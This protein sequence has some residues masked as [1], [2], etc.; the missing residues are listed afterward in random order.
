ME[1][2]PRLRELQREL[3]ESRQ[4]SARLLGESRAEAT[5]SREQLGA[6]QSSRSYRLILLARRALD[7]IA[8]GGTHRRGLYVRATAL[9]V[10]VARVARRPRE[11]APLIVH[12]TLPRSADPLVSIVIP[13]YG[14]WDYTARCLESIARHHEAQAVEV[15][16]VDDKSPDRSL[17]MLRQIHGVVVVALETNLGFTRAANAG[18]AASKGRHVVMLNND[19][20]V[21]SGWLTALLRVVTSEPDVG[22]VGAKLVFPDGRLQEAGGIIFN[23]GNGW[24]YGKFDDASAPQYNFRKDVDYCSGAAILITRRLL[25]RVPG[26]DERYA[27]A[28]YEDADLAFEARKHG[29]RVIYEP[30]AIVIHHEGIS[31]GADENV[32]TKRFQPINRVKFV[33]K[34]GQVLEEQFPSDGRSVT[35]ASVR[36]RGNGTIVIV[37]HMVPRWREDAGSLRMHRILLALRR[38]SY[39]VI[40]VPEN[41][42][43]MPE[44]SRALEAEG[45]LVWYGW[46]DFWGYLRDIEPEIAMVMLSRTSVASLFIRNVREVLPNV[47]LAFD[48]VDLHFLRE[49]R[50]AELRDAG[51]KPKGALATRELELAMIRSADLTLVVSDYEKKVLEAV[52]P[53]ATVLVLPIVHDSVRAAPDDEPRTDITFVGSFQHDPNV[54]AV[55]W[56]VRDIFPLIAVKIPDARLVV[57]GMNPP[58]DVV[59]MAPQ[60]VQFLGWVDDL[61][62]IHARSRVSVAPLRYGAGVKG[63]VADAWANGVPVVMTMIAAEGMQVIPG[64][65][66]LLA[67]DAEAFADAVAELYSDDELWR[68]VVVAGRAHVDLMFGQ[69]RVRSLLA[70]IIEQTR[71]ASAQRAESP[72][73]F[74]IPQLTSGGT[75]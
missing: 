8:P 58:A 16:V 40:L 44:Y 55:R 1:P 74:V 29:L 2:D 54:D 60:N 46:G 71:L 21:T 50:R 42:A 59:A 10:R 4:E 43:P 34:W 48:T 32:G 68:S 66:A 52:V 56:L 7:Q 47:P 75:S 5:W 13:I 38:M 22:I 15:I 41:R 64:E 6:L 25:D 72:V 14:K 36:R 57:V 49:Q 30:S 11:S 3:D 73:P 37:D 65:T 62:P 19:A 63:K 67:D 69:A 39:D 27:P 35:R 9:A 28:Y 51:G 70:D 53:T 18:I 20:E 26:F 23:D 45:V 17:H 31:H 12:A 33:E 61:Q 24:N